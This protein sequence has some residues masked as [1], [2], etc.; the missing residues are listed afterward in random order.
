MA[1]LYVEL[2]LLRGKER[3]NTNSCCFHS[4]TG[5]FF[6]VRLFFAL[7]RYFFGFMLASAK[8][9]RAIISDHIP[10]LR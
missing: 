8:K 1:G 5:R 6:R 2:P 9:A 7:P 10:R 4:H 3:K